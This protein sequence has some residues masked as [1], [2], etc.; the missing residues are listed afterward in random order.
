MATDWTE[1]VAELLNM[2]PETISKLARNRNLSFSDFVAISQAI[3]DKDLEKTKELLLGTVNEQD[4]PSYTGNNKSSLPTTPTLPTTQP[5][6][7][8]N[9]QQ[10]KIDDLKTGNKVVVNTLAGEPA[11][12]NVVRKTGTDEYEVASPQRPMDKFIV[13]KDQI[14][15]AINEGPRRKKK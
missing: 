7:G 6:I 15:S 11:Q 14:V 10:A 9:N 8:N 12:A 1:N 3:D 2:S 13:K 4:V 5:T